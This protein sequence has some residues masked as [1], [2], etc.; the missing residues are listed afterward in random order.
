MTDLLTTYT[1]KDLEA[2]APTEEII[3]PPPAGRKIRV[4]QADLFNDQGALFGHV[5]Q[6]GD[7]E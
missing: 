4:D 1:L 2:A 7:L 5:L 6:P 3:P